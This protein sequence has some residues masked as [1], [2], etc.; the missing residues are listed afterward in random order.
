MVLNCVLVTG[1]SGMAGWHALRLLESNKIAAIGTS[2]TPPRFAQGADVEWR[3]WDLLNCLS[4]GELTCLFPNVD[5]VLHLGAF[6]PQTAED[7]NDYDKIFDINVRG[8][9]CIAEWALKMNI[10]VVFLSSATIY[11]QINS[12]NI[13]EEDAKTK[14]SF[15]GFYSYSKLLAEQIFQYFAEKGLRLVI[16]RPSAMYGFGLPRTKMVVDFIYKARNNDMI[17]LRPPVHDQFNLIHAQDVVMAAIQALKLDAF[18]IYN[19]AFNRLY[20]I[21]DIATVVC[22]TVGRGSVEVIPCTKKEKPII[23]FDLNCDRARMTF[24]FDPKI[25]L[26]NGIAMMWDAMMKGDQLES[27]I[28]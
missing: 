11:D 8:S 20:T 15:G 23:R 9:L 24:M 21:L 25:T 22:K 27:K 14:G 4:P 7:L 13:S 2:R 28:L 10:P 18:G 19:V 5:A 17:I 3:K 1:A 26:E 16:L 12:R 6:V